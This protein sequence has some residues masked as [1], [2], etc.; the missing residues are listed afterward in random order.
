MDLHPLSPLRALGIKMVSIKTKYAINKV[1]MGAR[2]RLRIVCIG[3][4]YSGLMM[5]IIVSQKMEGHDI[6]FQVYEANEDLGGTW[7][8][9]RS[10]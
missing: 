3:S 4:G 8:L 2:R 6:D 10:V 7:L 1:A 9:N 5:A